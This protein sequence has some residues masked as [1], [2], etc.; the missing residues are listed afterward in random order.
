MSIIEELGPIRNDIVF[1]IED[2]NGELANELLI[3]NRKTVKDISFHKKKI[4]KPQNDW[5]LLL[6]IKFL[7]Y[8]PYSFSCLKI[9]NTN[10]QNFEKTFTIY[11]SDVAIIDI[12]LK[13]FLDAFLVKLIRFTPWINFSQ[14]QNCYFISK[15]FLIDSFPNNHPYLQ[16]GKYFSRIDKPLSPLITLIFK[17]YLKKKILK[18]NNSNIS[19]K[20]FID[21]ISMLPGYVYVVKQGLA[22]GAFLISDDHSLKLLVWVPPWACYRIEQTQYI[23]LDASFY[24]IRPYAYCCVNS[25]RHNESVPFAL[26]IGLSESLDLYESIYC[27]REKVGISRNILSKIP[28]LSVLGTALISFCER[29]SLI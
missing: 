13:N 20:K 14:T 2:D 6:F 24:A 16:F 11:E 26:S 21:I 22:D 29:R 1:T 23:E 12:Y 17:G 18:H 4:I 15:Q 19:S 10:F 5:N 27:C 25:I 8:M 9:K 3:H 28:V 7:N